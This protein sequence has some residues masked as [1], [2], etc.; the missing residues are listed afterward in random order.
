VRGGSWYY[1]Q[2]FARSAD[3]IRY[4]PSYRDYFLGFR[5]VCSSRRL[6]VVGNSSSDG[7]VALDHNL[8]LLR[9]HDL[10]VTFLSP[11][12]PDVNLLDHVQTAL[13]DD[14]SE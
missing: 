13:H 9:A 4:T 5:V 10:A 1:D 12:Q 3:R 11:P 14:L 8:R 2:V 7:A 6:I